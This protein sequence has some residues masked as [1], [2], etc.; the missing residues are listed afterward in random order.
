MSS[1]STPLSGL[2]VIELGGSLAAPFAGQ[3]FGD[4][5]A[6]VIKVERAE[7]DDSRR[8]GEPF[9]DGSSFSFHF[10]NRNKRSVVLNLRETGDKRKLIDL[11][12]ERADIVI[13]NLRPGQVEK[14]GLGADDLRALKPSLIYCNLGAFGR[15]G[16]LRHAPGYDPLMQAFGGIM[17]VV[18]E[19][20]RDPVR[21]G[22]SM[23]DVGTGMWAVVGTLAALNRRNATGEGSVVDV[24]LLETAI[25]WMMGYIPRYLNHGEI[26]RSMG[27]GQI[28][29]APYQAF[30]TADGHL[31][32]AAGNDKLFRNLCEA[33]GTQH[34][35]D[36]A[37]FLTNSDRSD[38]RDALAALITEVMI[39]DSTANW[40]KRIEAVGVPCAPVNNIKQMLE[41]DQVKALDIIHTV[42]GHA[43]LSQTLLP[44]SFDG[45]RHKPHRG[46]PRIGEHNDELFAPEKVA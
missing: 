15:V 30:R 41:H 5:G 43:P 45:D 29:I 39:Q 1:S 34:W 3:V 11:I 19:E 20:G 28:G 4:L 2:V 22:P 38:N 21:V 18:G 26:A 10:T 25:A 42:P 12:V 35:L 8:W 23:V 7:G 36:D 6:D 14:L 27:S 37:R 44:V 16:P 40:I 31:I 24:S 46:P 17:S 32:V 9:A 13:Q 33:F